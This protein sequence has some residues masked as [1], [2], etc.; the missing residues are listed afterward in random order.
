MF[1]EIDRNWS[2]GIKSST[3]SALTYCIPETGRK[4]AYFQVLCNFLLKD[5]LSINK[6]KHSDIDIHLCIL[7][8][9]NKRLWEQT[10]WNMKQITGHI[11]VY[12]AFDIFHYIRFTYKPMVRRNGLCNPIEEKKKRRKKEKKKKRREIRESSLTSSPRS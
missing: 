9:K 11:C 6:T 2:V 12:T 1:C 8:I 4:T 5:S 10:F 7:L 3:N